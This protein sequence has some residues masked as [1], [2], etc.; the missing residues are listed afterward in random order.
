MLILLLT[1]AK[2]TI[3]LITCSPWI[4][5]FSLKIQVLN[6]TIYFQ[7]TKLKLT[8]VFG[9]SKTL[10]LIV[11]LLYHIGLSKRLIK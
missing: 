6:S 1:P 7:I 4:I 10:R 9:L 5:L 11:E 8:Q 2:L 3:D